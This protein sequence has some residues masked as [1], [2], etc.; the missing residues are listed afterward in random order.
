M[1]VGI[2]MR[3]QSSLCKPDIPRVRI[4]RNE[5]THLHEADLEAVV[6]EARAVPALHERAGHHPALL[7]DALAL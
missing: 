7:V 2:G 4:P 1:C 5:L 6:H 3:K